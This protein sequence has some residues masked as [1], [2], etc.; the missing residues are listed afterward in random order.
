MAG[1]SY[2]NWYQ[3]FVR[4]LRV[5]DNQV[6]SLR[7][8]DLVERYG[9]KQLQGTYWSIATNPEIYAQQGGLDC[10]V[11]TVMKLAA[12]P[13]RL[14]DYGD[15]V[16]NALVNWGYAISDKSIRRW[17]RTDLPPASAWPQPSSV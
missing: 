15:P 5:T 7:R 12:V 16:R 13:T 1:A 10:P 4:V 9:T 6:R 11:A 17:Y 14:K 8:R 3:Q 2:W